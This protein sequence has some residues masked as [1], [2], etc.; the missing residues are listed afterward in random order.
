MR[1][2]TR[3]LKDSSASV[4]W[5]CCLL[6]LA[7]VSVQPRAF[8]SAAGAEP[9]LSLKVIPANRMAPADK[10]LIHAKRG[11][12]AQAAAFRGYHLSAGHWTHV[13]VQCP[14]IPGYL[15]L[16]YRARIASGAEW[17]FTALVPRGSGRVQVV[18]VLYRSAS[19]YG[20][21][22]A[23]QHTISVFN[24]VVPADV[25]AKAAQM[26][27]SWL[28]LATCYAAVA[29]AEPRIPATNDSNPANLNAPL[30][31]LKISEAQSTRQVVFTD[32]NSPSGYTV[33]TISLNQKGRVVAASAQT[34]ANAT[35]K[36]LNPPAPK[37][38]PLSPQQ[39]PTEKPISPK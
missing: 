28:Q 35:E 7:I 34:S 18:P 29:G 10:A 31:T 8:A 3:S 9:P 27:G 21:A 12:L 19:P 15:L 14:E 26:N 17:L 32:R 36:L 33:W 6:I 4:L 13:E 30:P 11:E 1:N 39:Q 24:Q 20:P 38:V 22:A 5:I 37:A 2:R 25:A 16:H 23:A